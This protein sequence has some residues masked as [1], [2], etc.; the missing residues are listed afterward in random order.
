MAAYNTGADADP[1]RPGN[2]KAS[3][4]GGHLDGAREIGEK[5]SL[6]VEAAKREADRHFMLWLTTGIDYQRRART[7]CV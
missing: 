4:A 6:S 3:R 2:E 5:V 1:P 7:R